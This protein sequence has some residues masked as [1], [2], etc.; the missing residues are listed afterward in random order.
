MERRKGCPLTDQ[1]PPLKS[2]GVDWSA[3]S[4]PAQQLNKLS[5]VVLA[6]NLTVLPAAGF[7]PMN[8][9]EAFYYGLQ[10]AALQNGAGRFASP[11]RRPSIPRSCTRAEQGRLAEREPRHPCQEQPT[12]CPRSFTQLSDQ[13]RDRH[14][15][16]RCPVDAGRNHLGV[17][18]VP[19]A[20]LPQGFVPLPRF[21]AKQAASSWPTDV[22]AAK[23]VKPVTT[24]TMIRLQ[25]R[26]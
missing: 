3:L 23:A 6:P 14:P 10:P 8:W 7:A 5:A 15:G 4:D 19:A 12:P 22:V 20:Q 25:R 11:P 16:E 17:T 9:S 26:R 18:N 1:F 24:T 13:L 2:S 21:L